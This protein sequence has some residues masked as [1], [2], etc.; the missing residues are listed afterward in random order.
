MRLRRACR[1]S[2]FGEFA[3]FGGCD[4]E[5]PI[6]PNQVMWRWWQLLASQSPWREMPLDD[7]FGGIGKLLRELLNEGRDIDHERR[8]VRMLL[9][10]RDHGVFR[11]SQ[12]C[13]SVV[14]PHEFDC[15]LHALY[16]VTRELG[17]TRGNLQDTLTVFDSELARAEQAAAQGWNS[18]VA[19]TARN[20][21]RFADDVE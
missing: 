18:G 7:A 13:E 19:L 3:P 21:Q 2:D 20:D 16:L 8:Q 1:M 10:A 15:L 4:D 12:R 14:L 11:R 6:W 5:L 9:A 17:L